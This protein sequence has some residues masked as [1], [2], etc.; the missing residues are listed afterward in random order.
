MKENCVLFL[1]TKYKF[2]IHTSIFS[3]LSSMAKLD[4]LSF[5]S[6]Q[7]ENMIMN[8]SYRIINTAEIASVF[9]KKTLRA[10]YVLGI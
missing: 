1:N 6:K 3:K 4:H 2:D 10:V 7:R 8:S 5:K 9:N